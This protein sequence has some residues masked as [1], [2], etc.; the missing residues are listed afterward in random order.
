MEYADHLEHLTTAVSQDDAR[1]RLLSAV[2]S[3]RFMEATGLQPVTTQKMRDL[4][5]PL[6]DLPGRDHT[7]AVGI[8]RQA[9]C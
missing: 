7:H 1:E 3:L 9:K 4:L 8:R 6:D 2:R 5:R